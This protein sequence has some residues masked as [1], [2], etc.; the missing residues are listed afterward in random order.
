MRMTVAVAVVMRWVRA[1]VRIT[2]LAFL[3]KIMSRSIVATMV[4]V[5][6]RVSALRLLAAPATISRHLLLPR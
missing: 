4:V 3:I 2:R 1:A 5:V 6:G